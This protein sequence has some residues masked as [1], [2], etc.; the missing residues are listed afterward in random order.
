MTFYIFESSIEIFMVLAQSK[1]AAIEVFKD[2][3]QNLEDFTCKE[4]TAVIKQVYDPFTFKTQIAY[5]KQ[6][7]FIKG[8]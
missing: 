7:E 3:S 8:G 2:Q 5:Q 4:V 6:L 1:Q